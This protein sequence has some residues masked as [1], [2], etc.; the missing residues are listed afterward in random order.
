MHFSYITSLVNI[1]VMGIHVFMQ[2]AA[3][4]LIFIKH[5]NPKDR[6]R[7]FIFSFFVM[8]A[9]AAMGELVATLHAGNFLDS[10]QLFEPSTVILG[11][12]NFSLLMWY[13]V[14]VL[15]P[16]WLTLKRV[17]LIVLPWGALLATF[18]ASLFIEDGATRIFSLTRLSKV[19]GEVNV[20]T[21]VALAATMFPYAIWIASLCCR[22]KQ[23]MS[24][25]P[26]IRAVI[27]CVILMSI[28]YFCSRGLQFFWAYMVHEVLYLVISV[29]ILYVE[30]YERLHIPYERVRTY[31]T[32]TFEAIPTQTD[33][34]IKE[35]AITLCDLLEDPDVWQNPD[36]TRDELVQMVGTNR[37]YIQEAAKQMG[38][39]SITDMLHKRRI[40]YICMRLRE[41]P[42]INLQ[43]LFYDAGYRSR[44]TGWRRFTTIVGCT[45]SEFVEKNT[46]PPE[47]KH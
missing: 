5:K 43:E 6:S 12:M 45:P 38:F 32:P 42:G 14:E 13:L 34:T 44:T 15:R 20:F 19:I 8:S 35:V 25:R 18:V 7:W 4:V 28:T 2:L 11:Y 47:Q 37:T 36:L 31:Y 23:Q 30:H 1:V 9:L 24:Y 40:E 41:E 3:A 29:L 27:I 22:N 21:R 39:E 26:Y 17:V 10:F 33:N 16:H 46:P